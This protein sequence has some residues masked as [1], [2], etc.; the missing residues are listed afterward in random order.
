MFDAQLFTRRLDGAGIFVVLLLSVR[1]G[2]YSL[3]RLAR[4]VF[5]VVYPHP[6]HTL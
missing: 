4:V 6:L 1:P 5:A 3:D 2:R